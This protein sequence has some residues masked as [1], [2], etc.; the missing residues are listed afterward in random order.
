MGRKALSLA[1][2]MCLLGVG[3]EPANPQSGGQH[4]HQWTAGLPI[5]QP[6]VTLT[7]PNTGYTTQYLRCFEIATLADIA[8]APDWD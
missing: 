2:I 7:I 1:A 4:H 8:S 3:F 5:P 6:I